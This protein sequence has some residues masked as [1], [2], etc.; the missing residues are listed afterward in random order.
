MSN[1]RWQQHPEMAAR[2]FA[3]EY[4]PAHTHTHTGALGLFIT[5]ANYLTSQVWVRGKTVHK[6]PVPVIMF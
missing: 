1:V 5:F 3:H 6:P 4:T 2:V